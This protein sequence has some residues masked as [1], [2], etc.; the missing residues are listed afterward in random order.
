MTFE[1]T[2]LAYALILALLQIGL[3]ATLRTLETGLAYNAGTRDKPAPAPVGKLTG[4][5][6]RAQN[7]LLETLPIF[8]AALLATQLI[9]KHTHLTHLGTLLYFWGRVVYIPLYAF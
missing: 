9:G 6:M 3:T 2:Y 1:L 7:N 5:M 4:R 8:I